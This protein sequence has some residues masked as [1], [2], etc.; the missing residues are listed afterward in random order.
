MSAPLSI[1]QIYLNALSYCLALSSSLFLFLDVLSGVLKQLRD[2][3]CCNGSST[4]THGES[5]SLKDWKR[6]VQLHL[7][8]QVVTWHGHFDAVWERHINSAIGCS[9]ES[10]WSVPSEEW[11]RS[12]SLVGLEHVNFALEGS[13]HVHGSWL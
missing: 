9:N 1:M 10:L 2:N 5:L 3:T 4:L 6:I 13:S 11:F 8:S 7:H 12:A